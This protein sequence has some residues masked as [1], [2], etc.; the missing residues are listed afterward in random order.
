MLVNKVITIFSRKEDLEMPDLDN[1]D[2]NNNKDTKSEDSN[3]VDNSQIEQLLSR[4]KEL[5]D[6]NARTKAFNEKVINEKKEAERKAKETELKTKG[7]F[8]ELLKLKQQELDEQKNKWAERDKADQARTLKDK[9][10]ELASELTTD[11][12]RAK[13]LA[14]EIEQRIQLT[15]DG[16]KVTDGQGNLTITPVAEL[17]E[18]MKKNYDFL[19]DG[20]QSTGSGAKGSGNATNG[21]RSLKDMKES[22]QVNLYNTNYNEWKRLADAETN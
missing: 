11:Q 21:T 5:E 3:K 20:L 1:Q 6:E 17:L 7:D 15:A 16:V 14:K 13:I 18:Q 9:A 22:E 2:Q 10:L 19:V 8:E 12:R 4:V